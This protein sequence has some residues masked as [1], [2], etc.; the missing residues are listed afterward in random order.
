MGS[1]T[2]RAKVKDYR[3]FLEN[4]SQKPIKIQ[5][6]ARGKKIDPSWQA[7]DLYDDSELIDK[8]WDLHCLP[9]ADNTV[10]CY[11]CNAVLEHVED[12]QLCVYEMF[13]TLVPGGQIWVDVPFMQFYHP[14]PQ[15]NY[16]WTSEG[17]KILLEDFRILGGGVGVLFSHEVGKIASY[18]TGV[19]KMQISTH[20]LSS[21]KDWFQKY[22]SSTKHPRLYSTCYAWGEKK[23]EV[24]NIK[25][26]YMEWRKL[27][28]YER[29][30][31][32][33][34]LSLRLGCE[35]ILK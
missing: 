24:Q 35:D 26:D 20:A 16:R 3:S 25:R 27:C 15:D 2:T 7:I 18:T 13:R 9:I 12:P 34:D 5:I 11:V 31:I 21:I 32:P 14:H 23:E 33:Y 28:Y 29:A 17:L 1:N 6:G 22:D 4:I 8:N 30:K 19:N 10:D